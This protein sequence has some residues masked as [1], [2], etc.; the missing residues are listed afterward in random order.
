MYRVLVERAGGKDLRKLPFEDA[1]PRGRYIA[2]LED[3]GR[4]AAAN[5]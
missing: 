4:L 1:I 2:R 3:R 5:L